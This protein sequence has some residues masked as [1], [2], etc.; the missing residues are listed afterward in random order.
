M[1]HKLQHN[2]WVECWVL[3]C[4][5]GER[6]ETLLT[7]LLFKPHFVIDAMHLIIIA[8]DQPIF[9]SDEGSSWRQI[10]TRHNLIIDGNSTD[11]WNMAPLVSKLFMT[12]QKLHVKVIAKD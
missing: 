8:G 3:Y 1:K 11:K 7:T 6:E 2:E 12:L 10:R 9:L 5:I 4:Y